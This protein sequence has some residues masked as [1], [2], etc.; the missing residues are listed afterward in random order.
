MGRE[1]FTLE[2]ILSK[3]RENSPTNDFTSKLSQGDYCLQL[4]S[5]NIS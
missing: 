4:G 3:D 2:Q 1:G 5:M